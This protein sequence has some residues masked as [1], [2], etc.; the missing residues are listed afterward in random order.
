MSNDEFGSPSPKVSV[1]TSYRGIG[2]S[3]MVLQ[4]SAM[5]E[6]R[7]HLSFTQLRFH[8][9][10]KQG[11][12]FH[13]VTASN[14]SGEAVVQYFSGQT[15][16]QPDACGSYVRLKWDDTSTLASICK[17]WGLANGIYHVGKWGHGED[18]NRLYRFPAFRQFKYHL[19]VQLN[20]VG[21]PNEMDCDDM[22]Y[23][24]VI[25]IGDFWRVFVR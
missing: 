21:D 11:R 16:E 7:R 19:R 6:L 2:K 13:V 15:D 9:R 23:N 3:H 17:D 24:S 12:T 10:K 14:S 18:Q 25:S 8:C 20:N 22:A 5:K 1:E 4:K